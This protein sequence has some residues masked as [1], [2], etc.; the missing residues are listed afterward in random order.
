VAI[1]AETIKGRGIRSMQDTVDSH[2]LPMDD[3]QYQVALDDL[4]AAPEVPAKGKHRA[5]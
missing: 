1:I 4:A 3:E 2:Y 5:R